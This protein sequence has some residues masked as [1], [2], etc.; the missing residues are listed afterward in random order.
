MK[1]ISALLMLLLSIGLIA[2]LSV[3]DPNKQHEEDDC[4]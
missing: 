4:R 3:E 1:V 2:L